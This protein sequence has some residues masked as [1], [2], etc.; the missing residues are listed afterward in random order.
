VQALQAKIFPVP[1]WFPAVFFRCCV[2]ADFAPAKN[3]YACFC[4]PWHPPGTG[5]KKAPLQ[6]LVSAQVNRKNQ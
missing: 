1:Y 5:P 2:G 3:R 6:Q 4:L